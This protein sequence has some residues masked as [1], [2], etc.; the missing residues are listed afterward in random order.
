MYCKIHLDYFNCQQLISQGILLD[1]SLTLRWKGM[2]FKR[3]EN[4]FWLSYSTIKILSCHWCQMGDNCISPGPASFWQKR[5]SRVKLV[6][7]LKQHPWNWFFNWFRETE[8]HLF[9]WFLRKKGFARRF[10]LGAQMQWQKKT[11]FD[12]YNYW[13]RD[14]VN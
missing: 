14:R 13:A 6:L 1:Y 7:Q 10:L 11:C 3:D 8:K 4:G 5:A 12:R 9:N 2:Y